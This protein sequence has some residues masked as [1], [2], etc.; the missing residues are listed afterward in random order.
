M[1][2]NEYLKSFGK[3][4]E[5]VIALRND[6]DFLINEPQMVKFFEVYEFFTKAAGET[7]AAK[8]EPIKLAPREEHGGI[9]ATFVVFD[10]YGEILEGF[11]KIVQHLSAMTIDVVRGEEICI[12]VTV[13]NVFIPKAKG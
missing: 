7:E 1:S 2:N 8:V 13:P 12:S 9:T 11:K 10:M 6:D 4:Y 5:K 3:L